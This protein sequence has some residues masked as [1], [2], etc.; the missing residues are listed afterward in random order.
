MLFIPKKKKLKEDKAENKYLSLKDYVIEFL[1]VYFWID[2]EGKREREREREKEREH[3]V[4]GDALK[5]MFMMIQ[6]RELKF[7]F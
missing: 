2:E 4:C 1:M 5:K 7:Y 3:F 6:E